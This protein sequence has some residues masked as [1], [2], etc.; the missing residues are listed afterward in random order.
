MIWQDETKYVKIF[1][2]VSLKLKFVCVKN[3]RKTVFFSNLKKKTLNLI[4][5]F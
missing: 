5:D 2:S 1:V 4:Y 3:C